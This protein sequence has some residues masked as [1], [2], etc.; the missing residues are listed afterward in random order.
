MHLDGFSRDGRRVFGIVSEG[1]KHSF[2]LV[3]D[4]DRATRHTEVIH[5]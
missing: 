2:A 1:G 3:F 4:Y 5:I